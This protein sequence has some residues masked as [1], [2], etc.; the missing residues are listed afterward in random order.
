MTADRRVVIGVDT[1]LDT[2]HIAAITDAGQL[3]GNAEFGTTPTGY[4]VALRWAQS[5]GE[6]FIAT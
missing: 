2:I 1:H 3:L 5:F 4:Y 6:V